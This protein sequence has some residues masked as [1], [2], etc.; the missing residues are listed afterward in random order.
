MNEDKSNLENK[1]LTI[2]R[3]G[4][5]HPAAPHNRS[6]SISTKVKILFLLLGKSKNLYAI[7]AR[8]HFFLFRSHEDTEIEG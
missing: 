3:I 4:I 6:L 2:A 7:I 8:T 1:L 5:A